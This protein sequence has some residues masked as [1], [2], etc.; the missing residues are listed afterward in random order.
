VGTSLA[1]EPLLA[2]A[3]TVTSE[4]RVDSVLQSIVQGLASQPGVALARIWLVPSADLLSFCHSASDPADCLCLVA[5]AGTPINSPGE[6]W[7]FLQGHFARMPFNVG[8]V[9]QVATSRQPILIE[10][11]GVQNDWIVRPEWAKREEIR[12]FVGHPLIFRDKLLGVIAVFSRHP[13]G[14]QEFTW[15]GLFANQAAVAI[16]NARAEQALQSS[17]RNLATIINTIPTAA[18]TT[19]PD[20]YCDFLN[21]VWLDYA[22]MSAEQA[23]GWG[24]AEAIHPEDREQLVE[25]WQSSLA[26]GIPVDTEARIRRFDSSYRWFLIRGNPLR[27]ES[28][29]ILKWYG[30]CTDIED[31]KRW[32]QILRGRELSWRQIV[33]NIPGLV[34]TTG[35]MGD[36]EFLNRQ[37]LEYFGKT[38]EEL[39][40]WALIDAVHP[41]DLPG[42]IETRKRS[43]EAGQIYDVEHRCR[44]ADGV[45]RWFQ[46]RGLPV[47]DPENKTTAWYLL[48]T[49]IDDRKRAE[50]ALQ[51]REL[52]ARSLLDTMPG[53]LARLSPDGTPEFF[54]RQFL[55]YLGRS[56]EEIRKWKTSDIIHPDDIAHNVEVFGNAIS[57]GEP[58]DFEYR[59]RRFDGVYRWFHARGVPLRDVEGRILH[60]NALVTDIDDRKKAE[61]ALRSSQRDLSLMID[62]IPGM[63]H[64]AR[65]DGYLDYFNRPWLEYMG[66]SLSDIEGW[67]WT[68]RIHPDDLPGIVDK[69][70]AC[71]A[72]GENFEYE[73]RVRRGDG[74]YR[75][76]FHRKVPLRD[77]RGNIVRWYGTSLDIED[78]KRAEEALKSS[79]RNLSLMINAIPTSIGVMRADGTPLYGNQ[80][81]TDYT[82]LTLEEMQKETFRSRIFHPD[83]ME[84]LR[85]ERRLAFSRPVPFENEQRALGKDGKYRW[86][87]FRYKPLLDET[88]KID[89]WY[90]AAFDI[91]DRKRVEAQVEQAY[92]RLA[93]AQRLSKTGSFITDLVADEHNWSEETFRIFDFDPATK[94]TVQRI[95]EIIHP[96]DLPS[97]E[98]TL[99]RAMTGADVD[100]VFRIVTSRNVM[101][102]IRGMA[103]IMVQDADRPLFIGALQDITESKM[104]E[105]ALDRARSELARVARVTTMNTLT[106]S[107][108]HEIKQP[109]ASLVTNA[110]IALRRLNA[111]P[112]NVDGARETVQRT[113][114][115]ANRASDVITRLRALFSKK[116]FTLETLD[117][118][119]VTTE[120]IALS[121]SDLQR[122]RVILRSELAE[123]LPPVIGD[124]VQLQQVI[125]NLIRN[126]SDAMACV[127]DRPRQL[128][129]RTQRDGDDRVRLSVQDAG[130]GVNPQDFERLFEAFY[131]TKSG[132][133][134]IGLSLSRSIIEKHQGRL[135]AEPND[136]PGTTFSFSIPRGPSGAK[137]AAA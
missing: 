52:D 132:G 133:M 85:A 32:E 81:V 116:E 59:I 136:G 21:Q 104:A 130:C 69:W 111:D 2:L 23:Q 60:W 96:E 11:V 72:S 42:V 118:N 57:A 13:L 49:D 50:E 137:D 4:Q 125:L 75:W 99:A 98:A 112:P 35:A 61:E 86:F 117:L 113:I 91:D 30:T 44:R 64:T 25:V 53:L 33:D 67:N 103:R 83:D 123:D 62:A 115:D 109:L 20:G 134:G 36:V 89:R 119:E 108:A 14:Q 90:M 27:D 105:E 38:T 126:A 5:S 54:N 7:C 131:T 37:T 100:F 106:A 10:D 31:R 127:E 22:G 114:R 102:H 120:V 40:D 92:L 9:G 71:V 129:V 77:E 43:I 63:I 88:G 80:G 128:L 26:S 45:Y 18:W 24:W 48:L 16:S 110:S 3:V 66:C 12:S 65:P 51:S 28:G 39:K 78:R 17:E 97:F 101:K 95:R 55:Q 41:D 122:D 84:R 19:R 47:R 46:V 76:M 58:F 87:L 8:K 34:A 107:I 79:E 1:A 70:R 121:L 15:L 82:G 135:W 73:T 29:N 124:R 94:V 74:Q 6:D 68:A 56:M 93:E